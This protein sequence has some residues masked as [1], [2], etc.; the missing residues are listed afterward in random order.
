MIMH[1]KARTRVASTAAIMAFALLVFGSDS[2]AAPDGSTVPE[3]APARDGSHDFDFIYG[4]WRMPNHRL[5]QRLADSHEW[6]DFVTCDEG[7][8]LPGHIGDVDYLKASFWKDFVGVTVLQRQTHHRAL[9]L[10][11]EP[12]ACRSRRGLGED[13]EPARRKVVAKWQ[14]AFSTDN[15]KT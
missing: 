14:Q 9:H 8:P 11:R 10:D 5:K 13:R 2:V 12:R 1:L 4:K 3:T 6:V 15:G 7:S